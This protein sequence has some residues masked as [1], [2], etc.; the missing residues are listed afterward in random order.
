V[1]NWTSPTD[2]K[3]LRSFLGLA[4]YYRKF[5]KNYGLIS[6]P[7]TD[8]LKKNTPF[9]WTPQLQQSFEELKHALV[10][11]P[12]LSLPNFAKPF[13]VET[14]A[15]DRGVGAVLMQE[16]HPIAYLSKAL[17]NKSQALST[18]EKECLAIILA[19]DKWKP[20]LQHLPFSI[21]TDQRSLVH[22]GEQK[23]TNGVQH[24]AFVK[25]LGL[26]YNMVDKKGLENKAADALSRKVHHDES[27][28]FLLANP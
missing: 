8:I 17:S 13:L 10:T 20:Y 23:L 16:G 19:I 2:T 15:S 11:A 26:Q 21:A 1:L 28:P 6:R 27:M 14:D 9:L 7:L 18:Y 22:L 24:K 4:G 5:I 25:L 3:Q 12:V